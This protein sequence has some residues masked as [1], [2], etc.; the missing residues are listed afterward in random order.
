V[1]A[2]WS[3]HP[4]CGTGS[5]STTGINRFT[6]NR[7]RV[8]APRASQHPGLSPRINAMFDTEHQKLRTTRVAPE[9]KPE[10][11]PSIVETGAIAAFPTRFADPRKPGRSPVAGSVRCLRRCRGSCRVVYEVTPGVLE[12]CVFSV[13]VHSGTFRVAP[14]DRFLWTKLG[15]LGLH[16]YS[17]SQP[18]LQVTLQ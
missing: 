4:S 5:H 16:D 3:A 17:R 8:R 9:L 18:R 2:D 6:G 10:A 1:Q 14:Y 15:T 13:S 12:C 7:P 11:N